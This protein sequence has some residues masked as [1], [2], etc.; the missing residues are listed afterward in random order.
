[1]SLIR[2]LTIV[3]LIAV[4]YLAEAKG[5]ATG[6]T[7]AANNKMKQCAA[8]WQDLKAAG[9]TEGKTYK[10]FS[11]DCLKSDGVVPTAD[12]KVDDVKMTSQNKMKA[13]A[14]EWNQLKAADA[15]KGKSYKD[16][17]SECLKK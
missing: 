1:M 3:S 13:C 5:P 12:V 4:P 11:A 8:A 17:S 2:V 9:K 16:F 10:T 14:D 7:T 6:P 15:T